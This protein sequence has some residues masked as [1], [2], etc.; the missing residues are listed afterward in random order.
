[1]ITSN[2]NK[3]INSIEK[4]VSVSLLRLLYKPCNHDDMTSVTHYHI[5]QFMKGLDYTNICFR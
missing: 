2:Y 4:Y 5:K 3:S 1:L